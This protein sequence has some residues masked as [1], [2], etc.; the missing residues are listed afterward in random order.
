MKKMKLNKL[1]MFLL[2]LGV[3]I[4]VNLGNSVFEGYEHHSPS[5]SSSKSP[6][7]SSSKS[8]SHS[9]DSKSVDLFKDNASVGSFLQSDGSSSVSSGVM[10]NSKVA[11]PEGIPANEIP[12]GDED[13]YI[14][15]SQVVPPVC[16]KCPDA[17]VCPRKEDPPPCPPCARC[18]D[19]GYKCKLIPNYE[20]GGYPK[21]I[22]N[23]FSTFGM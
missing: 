19:P 22:L 21:P 17:A 5:H 4:F 12:S 3:L 8:P 18:P 7:H 11:L 9:S 15:K 23:D 2:L 14:L 13:L 20:V 1:N 6:S 16:P 10:T